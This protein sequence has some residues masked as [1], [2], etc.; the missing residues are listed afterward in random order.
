M[1]LGA[2]IVAHPQADSTIKKNPGRSRENQG[3]NRLDASK[4]V[5]SRPADQFHSLSLQVKVAGQNGFDVT[6]IRA[7]LHWVVQLDDTAELITSTI[8][9]VG[10][11][12]LR[13]I[14]G[15]HVTN[16]R[17]RVVVD[18]EPEHNFPFVALLGI[19]I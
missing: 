14:L 11:N 8:L 9:C 12:E 15:G 16:L 6:R 17:L 5:Q 13:V 1:L 7:L 2:R 3:E 19:E 10:Q 4:S 18:C